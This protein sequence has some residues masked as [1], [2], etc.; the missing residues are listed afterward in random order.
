MAFRSALAALALLL[1]VAGQA[2]AQQTQ[3]KEERP[4]GLPKKVEWTFNFDAG[5]G[6][7][8]FAH[9]LYQNR[10]DRPTDSLSD[11]WLE[12]S[13]KPALSGIWHLGGKHGELFGKFSAVGERTFAAP[14]PLVGA[15]ASSFKVEDMYIGWR[16]PK[17]CPRNPVEFIV[18]RAPYRIGHGMLV[19]DGASEGGSRGAFWSNAR[20]AWAFAAIGRFTPKHHTLEGFYLDRDELPESQTGTRLFGVN[21][22][23]ALGS[24]STFGATFMRAIADSLVARD[25]MNVY[26]LRAYTAPLRKLPALSF[27]LEYALEKNGD[28][29]S[30]YAWNAKV[31]Y[32]LSKLKWKPTL[33]YRYAIFEGDD[34]STPQSEAFDPLITGF[35][36][37][38]TWWQGEIGGEYF[39]SNSNLI[40]HQIR[41]HVTPSDNISGGVFGY[42]F[43]LQRAPA[44][45]TSKD[46]L[47]ELDGYCDW[48]ANSNF[49][50]S[51]IAALATPKD[52]VKQVFNRTDSFVY[53]MIY[54]AYSY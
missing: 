8:G 54:V 17:D 18:G 53:G 12:S 46:L 40:S 6:M 35:Y 5:L 28:L 45:I 27:E 30:S 25:G 29:L 32:E 15:E 13:A 49:T 7:F 36:D 26:N 14:P 33:S 39:L 42:L 2:R 48:K 16:C 47:T 52:A 9:S 3:A 11:N 23:Y 43:S 37:W 31:A 51:F 24:A 22:E 38:G 50:I 20:K 1:T 19:W 44:A 21:Y 10:P 34:P 41:V 4:T